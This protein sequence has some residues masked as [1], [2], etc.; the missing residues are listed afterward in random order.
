MDFVTAVNL[1]ISNPPYFLMFRIHILDID[2]SKSSLLKYEW[3]HKTNQI[4][5]VNNFAL[6]PSKT[7]R[8]R[9]DRSGVPERWTGT[10]F[11]KWTDRVIK[12]WSKLYFR[13]CQL[14]LGKFP[15]KSF[16]RKKN[17]LA[18]LIEKLILFQRYHFW[19]MRSNFLQKMPAN[20][21]HLATCRHTLYSN[22]YERSYT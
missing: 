10:M 6:N 12:V 1:K 18:I 22:L 11:L 5:F 20:Y 15:Y 14:H 21:L 19:A 17:L 2:E 13:Y 7:T 9:P 4:T 3:F 8:T 16:S